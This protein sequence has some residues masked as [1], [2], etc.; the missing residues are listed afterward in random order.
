M[1][2]KSGNSDLWERTVRIRRLFSVINC[3]GVALAIG[4]P[5]CTRAAA[6]PA[7]EIDL[8]VVDSPR[9]TFVSRLTISLDQRGLS[10][11]STARR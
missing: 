4:I 2:P 11:R 8:V 5:G 6:D 10:L 1:A 3:A 7:E 9:S